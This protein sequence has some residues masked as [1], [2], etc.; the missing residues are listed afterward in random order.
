[1]R[2]GGGWGVYS[3]YVSWVDYGYLAMKEIPLTQIDKATTALHD[4]SKLINELISPISVDFYSGN[5]KVHVIDGA[6]LDAIPGETATSKGGAEY[7]IRYSKVYNGVEFF[8][9]E[10]NVK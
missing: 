5:I 1:M 2:Y 3:V 4:A 9:I 10:R 8:R 6:S 7:P